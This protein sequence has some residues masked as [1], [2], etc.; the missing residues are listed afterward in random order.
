MMRYALRVSRI[1]DQRLQFRSSYEKEE[2]SASELLKLRP[3]VGTMPVLRRT[4]DSA[5]EGLATSVVPFGAVDGG[6][7]GTRCRAREDSRMDLSQVEA[8]CE[9]AMLNSHFCLVSFR[10]VRSSWA[11][12][13]LVIWTWR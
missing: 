5:P 13:A 12:A 11:R 6:A 9:A 4:R 7:L 2:M 10:L 1:V 8:G 3:I